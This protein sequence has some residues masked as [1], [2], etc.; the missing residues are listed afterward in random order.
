[1]DVADEAAKRE[2]VAAY[3]GVLDGL[4]P[5]QLDAACRLATR[6]CKFFPTPAD[7]F[8]HVQRADA[9]GLDLE[10]DEAWNRVLDYV[11][12]WYGNRRAPALPERIQYAARVAG[13]LGRIESCPTSELQW[14]RKQFVEAFKR[15]DE[16]ERSGMMLTRGEAKRLLANLRHRPGPHAL[17]A[18]AAEHDE[19]NPE[20]GLTAAR[21]AF[22]EAAKHLPEP[23]PEP[24]K[25]P[26]FRFPDEPD[27]EAMVRRQ[28]AEILARVRV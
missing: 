27:H 26:V 7:V 11:R 6:A 3:A 1:M 13:G 2:V 12:E 5:Q 15:F 20:V 16:L 9:A 18:P 23:K 28:A 19:P 8:T 14:V 17:P 24:T 21:D 10:A 4:T 25:G 22:A